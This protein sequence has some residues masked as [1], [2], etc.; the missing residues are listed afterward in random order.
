MDRVLLR[1]SNLPVNVQKQHIL[2]I[3][4]S[5]GKV[6]G[7]RVMGNGQALVLFED[8]SSTADALDILGEHRELME[9]RLGVGTSMDSFYHTRSKARSPK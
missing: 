1:F 6:E 4:M 7:L 9:R 3:V 8:D 2:S 5:F